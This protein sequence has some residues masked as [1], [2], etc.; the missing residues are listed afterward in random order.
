M[1]RA[2]ENAYLPKVSRCVLKSCEINYAPENV[3]SSLVPD[4]RGA[5]PT[6]IS[7]NLNFG[8]TEIMTKETVAEG[9]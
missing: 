3:V 9:F 8:E 2:N 4:E 5:P 1:Y 7:M 6:L